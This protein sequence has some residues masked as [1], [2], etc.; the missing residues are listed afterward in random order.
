MKL[1][2]ETLF[3]LQAFTAGIWGAF[4]YDAIRIVRRVIPHRRFFVSLE[5]LAFWGICALRGLQIMYENNTGG[6]RWFA[7]LGGGVGVYLYKKIISKFYVTNV[8]KALCVVR[9]K[10]TSMLK[11]IR[12]KLCKR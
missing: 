1:S 12:I 7:I 5:D 4:F 8:S 9:N 3:L 6:L 11:L 2:N 10:L